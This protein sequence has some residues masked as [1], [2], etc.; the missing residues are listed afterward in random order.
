[1]VPIMALDIGQKRTGIAMTDSLEMIAHPLKTLHYT[2]LEEL[3]CSLEII[4]RDRKVH[5][6]VVGLPYGND[7]EITQQAEIILQITKFL[8][9][10]LNQNIRWTF[11]EEI[12]T[13]AE[14]RK[15]LIESGVSRKKRRQPVDTFAAVQILNRY[16]KKKEGDIE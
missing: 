16:L 2:Q 4:I 3:L 7:G 13:T 10:R 6:I 11:Q 14:A 15:K 8:Q 1:M 12:L 5:T 9:K